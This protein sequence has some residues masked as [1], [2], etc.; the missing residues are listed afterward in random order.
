MAAPFWQCTFE[1][2]EYLRENPIMLRRNNEALE[3]LDRWAAGAGSTVRG[4]FGTTNIEGWGAIIA[5]YRAR[6]ESRNQ[7]CPVW[8]S[9]ASS[10]RR[11]ISN[12]YEH[13]TSDILNVYPGCRPSR[14]SP[15]NY[16]SIRSSDISIR[17]S[18]WDKIVNTD[19]DSDGSIRIYADSVADSSDKPDSDKPD[20]DK[21]DSDQDAESKIDWEFDE[22]C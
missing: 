4:G 11:D 18:D 8:T 3:Y 21:P 14:D 13:R 12:I 7:S 20:S 10:P 9:D 16:T 6:E 5:R 22:I 15:P 19:D 2:Q 17:S 1:Y